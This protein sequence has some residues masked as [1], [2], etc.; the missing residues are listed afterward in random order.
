MRYYTLKCPHC[1]NVL[2]KGS[3]EIEEQIGNPFKRC[4]FCG[5]TYVDNNINEWITMS[6]FKR[7]SFIVSKP[8]CLGILL[9][10]VIAGMGSGLLNLN[11]E[12]ATLLGVVVFFCT[13]ILGSFL[14]KQ[15]ATEQIKKSLK[16]TESKKYVDLLK[17]AKFKIYPIKG[18]NVGF[19]DDEFVAEIDS[20]KK[21]EETSI[22]TH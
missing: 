5:R 3:G 16:R 13:T 2:D 21:S 17:F 18:V 1:H 22:N 7:F 19:K 20:I 6:P 9:F 15:N 12:F 8:I 4:P 14:R 11:F 10:I